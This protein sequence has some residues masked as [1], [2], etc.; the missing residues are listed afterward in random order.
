MDA[1]L[2]HGRLVRL[3]PGVYAAPGAAD[4]PLVR[5]RAAQL[6]EPNAVLTH[7]AAARLTFWS[8]VRL[9]EVHLATSH[10]AGRRSGYVVVRRAVPADLVVERHGLRCTAPALTALDLIDYLGG[11]AIDVLLRSR[12]ATVQHLQDA[13]VATPYRRGNQGASTDRPRVTGESLVSTGAAGSS[14]A[15][16]SGHHRLGRQPRVVICGHPYYLDIGFPEI[17]LAVEIDGREFH[18]AA[19]DFERDRWR[20]NDLVNAGWR[21]LRFT[22]RMLEEAPQLVLSVITEAITR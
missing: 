14:T 11:E 2:K 13:L 20:Q 22:A 12:Q 18:T 4:L 15:P 6:W 7:Q 1:H 9:T 5:L 16:R 10:R 8:T 19:A 21:V 3:L 17:K